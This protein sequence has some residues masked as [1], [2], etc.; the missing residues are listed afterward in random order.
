MADTTTIDE[1]AAPGVEQKLDDTSTAPDK[2]HAADEHSQRSESTPGGSDD[3]PA[4]DDTP[5]NDQRG[6]REAAK[7]RKRAQAAE[8]ERDQLR[9]TLTA[10]QRAEVERLAGGDRRMADGSDLWRH[11]VTLDDLIGDD[12]QI[13]PTKVDNAVQGVLKASPHLR[14]RRGGNHV[15]DAGRI[16]DRPRAGGDRFLG[17]LRSDPYA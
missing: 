5:D 16:P 3:T 8:A 9:E 17:A 6:N 12:G 7:L 11:D 15:P 13:D 4:S 14:D 1:Q 10:M 2:E